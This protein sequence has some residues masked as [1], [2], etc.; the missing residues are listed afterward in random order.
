MFSDEDGLDVRKI[1]RLL[2]LRITC[3]LYK[4][5]RLLGI[6]KE[7]ILIISAYNSLVHQLVSALNKEKLIEGNSSDVLTIDKSQGTDKEVIIFIFHKGNKDLIE[8]YR[9]LNVAL[10]RAKNKFI[11][12]GSEK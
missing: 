3:M 10:T 11:I 1:K 9:R 6:K 8:N 12:V 7:E 4:Y 5:F 2:Q